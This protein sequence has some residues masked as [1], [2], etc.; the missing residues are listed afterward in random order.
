MKVQ[1]KN[2]SVSCTRFFYAVHLIH[3]SFEAMKNCPILF[4]WYYISAP[5]KQS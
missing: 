1:L 2:N 3:T 4:K 5:D